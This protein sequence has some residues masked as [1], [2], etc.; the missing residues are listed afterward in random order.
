MTKVIASVAAELSGASTAL[1]AFRAHTFI[2]SLEFGNVGVQVNV[3][4]ADHCCPTIEVVPSSIHHL[5][6]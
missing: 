2:V 3:L 1:D 6:W 5:N 4:L